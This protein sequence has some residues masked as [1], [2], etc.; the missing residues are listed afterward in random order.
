MH[1]LNGHSVSGAWRIHVG[2][3]SRGWAAHSAVLHSGA[4]VLFRGKARY[5][6]RRARRNFLKSR[7]QF[8]RFLAHARISPVQLRIADHGRPGCFH[9]KW[10]QPGAVVSVWESRVGLFPPWLEFAAS[11]SGAFE[12]LFSARRTK[13]Q[14]GLCSCLWCFISEP[15]LLPL[16]ALLVQVPLDH[17]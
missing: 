1:N 9:C 11:L 15:F 3:A 16:I 6:F 7:G 17:K 10:K 13:M 12:A 4:P 14:T 5:V 2:V 8:R